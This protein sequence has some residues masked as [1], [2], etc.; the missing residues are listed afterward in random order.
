[1]SNATAVGLYVV[2]AYDWSDFM[3]MVP[4][5]SD[6]VLADL[7]AMLTLANE[8]HSADTR[9]LNDIG[10]RVVAHEIKRRR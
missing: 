2:L 1:M 9:E 5:A 10:A 4:D 6:D 7:H 8:K 3:D